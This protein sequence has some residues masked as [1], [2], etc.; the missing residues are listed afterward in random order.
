MLGDVLMKAAAFATEDD[1][2]GFSEGHLIVEVL[3]AFIEAVDPIAT[4]LQFA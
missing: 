2:R 1:G 4:L 3:A